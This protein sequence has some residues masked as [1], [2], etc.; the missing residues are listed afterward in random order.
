M[1]YH[2]S[3]I[4]LFFSINM[5]YIEL[6]LFVHNQTKNR[7]RLDKFYDA[8]EVE[9]MN[10]YFNFLYKNNAHYDKRN[11]FVIFTICLVYM[12]V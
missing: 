3:L 1:L 7:K 5:H 6:H 4:F 8:N 9:R 12:C 10:L 11:Q 2:L